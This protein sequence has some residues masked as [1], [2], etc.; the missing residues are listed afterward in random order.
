MS[1]A[2]LG[3]FANDHVGS[4]A[5]LAGSF[6]FDKFRVHQT[7]ASSSHTWVEIFRNYRHL[8]EM[9]YVNKGLKEM[10]VPP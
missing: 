8:T 3:L 2:T 7:G 1:S 10:T 5:F 4:A 6:S 9:F